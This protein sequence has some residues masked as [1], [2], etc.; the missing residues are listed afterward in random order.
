MGEGPAR[1]FFYDFQPSAKRSLPPRMIGAATVEE[2]NVV[3]K[4]GCLWKGMGARAG[5]VLH[6]AHV[7]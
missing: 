1:H 2:H 4:S 6:H 3:L 5:V 7:A